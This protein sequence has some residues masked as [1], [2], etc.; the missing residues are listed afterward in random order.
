LSHDF[1]IIFYDFLLK[2][3]NNF[4]NRNYI[5]LNT[6]YFTMFSCSEPNLLNRKIRSTLSNSDPYV[7]IKISKVLLNYRKLMRILLKLEVMIQ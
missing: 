6:Y 3:Y 2:I 4:L 7:L 5:T 1:Y